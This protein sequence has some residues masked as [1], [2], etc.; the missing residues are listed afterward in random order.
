M[1]QATGL[2]AGPTAEVWSMTTENCGSFDSRCVQYGAEYVCHACNPANKALIGALQAQLLGLISAMHVEA[3]FGAGHVVS[4]DK[5][6]GYRTCRAI[7]IL[8]D[9]AVGKGLVPS[10]TLVGV[11]GMCKSR[12]TDPATMREVA[13]HVPALLVYFRD[14]ARQLGQT[15][16]MPITPPTPTPP[17]V[18]VAPGPLRHRGKVVAGFLGAIF[19]LAFGVAAS[20]YVD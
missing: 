15:L 20:Y 13:K 3:Q 5:V 1:L 14:V 11:I 7:G 12:P 10:S 8:G 4:A 16:H 18:P 9:L 17:G 19:F 2:G 6:I